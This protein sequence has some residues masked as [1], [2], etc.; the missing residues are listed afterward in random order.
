MVQRKTDPCNIDGLSP[1][2][3]RLD[4]IAMIERNRTSLSSQ[5]MSNEHR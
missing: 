3:Q 1:M 2:A 4:E 5:I